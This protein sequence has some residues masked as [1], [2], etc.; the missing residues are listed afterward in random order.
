MHFVDLDDHGYSPHDMCQCGEDTAP[1]RL[2]RIGDRIACRFLCD[3]CGTRWEADY[4]IE[5]THPRITT[6][7]NNQ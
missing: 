3:A 5:D 2:S 7:E 1:H 4:A 6:K